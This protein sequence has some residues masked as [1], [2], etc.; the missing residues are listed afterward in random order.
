[1]DEED[2][3]SECTKAP[4]NQK[5]LGVCRTCVAAKDTKIERQAKTIEQEAERVDYL[6]LQ[7]SDYEKAL[8]EKKA[9][10]ER[11]KADVVGLKA[12]QAKACACAFCGFVVETGGKEWQAVALEMTEHMLA[13]KDH[14]LA[15]L[16]VAQEEEIAHLKA[17]HEKVSQALA[18][19]E[20]AGVAPPLAVVTSSR[21]TNYEIVDSVGISLFLSVAN[22]KP[23]T[24]TRRLIALVNAVAAQGERSPDRPKI[25][26]LCGST[27][28]SD[29]FREANLRETL[30]GRIVLSIGCDF[31]S[32]DAQGLEPEAK[33]R[34]DELHKRK[35]D[36][37]DEIL[38]L[39]I[40]GYIGESTRSEID[41]TIAHGKPVRY[42]NAVA[43]QAEE[44]E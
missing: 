33:E 11:L 19:L 25:V 6:H 27:R 10:I 37:A 29:A 14:P 2:V 1:M 24:S 8:T 16:A 5:P 12:H 32:D 43:A 23:S 44:G 7:A 36:L 21:H 41:Y 17:G 40:G 18:D 42:L 9:E 28:F 4:N 34:L 39:N 38:V 30:A 3:C 31:K 22:S 20:A 26:C 15:K 13:C 35:I